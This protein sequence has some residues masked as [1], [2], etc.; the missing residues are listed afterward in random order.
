MFILQNTVEMLKQNLGVRKDYRKEYYPKRIVCHYYEFVY[1]LF[2]V[3]L[4]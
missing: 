2:F 3:A 4:D 1:D